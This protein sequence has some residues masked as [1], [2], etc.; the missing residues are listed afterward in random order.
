MGGASLGPQTRVDSVCVGINAELT[1][2]LMQNV[3]NP[4]KDV[5]AL[6][7]PDETLS[8]GATSKTMTL[9]AN[10]ICGRS[11]IQSAET[12]R[13]VLHY[14]GGATLAALDD[15]IVFPRAIVYLADDEID[16]SGEEGAVIF[17]CRLVAFPDATYDLVV[18]GVNAT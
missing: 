11:A 8:A 17:P 16:F 6:V 14:K 1:F 7:T 13:W 3:G 12:D 4:T 18:I 2:G 9:D 10:T 15:D 5:F